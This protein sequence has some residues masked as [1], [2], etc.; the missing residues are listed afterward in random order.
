MGMFYTL[1][2]ERSDDAVLAINAL[3]D[4]PFD[5][6]VIVGFDQSIPMQEQ[7]PIHV[8]EVQMSP[9]SKRTREQSLGHPVCHSFYIGVRNSRNTEAGDFLVDVL[10]KVIA[11]LQGAVSLT[12]Y[13]ESLLFRKTTSEGVEVFNVEYFWAGRRLEPI[14]HSAGA[15]IRMTHERKQL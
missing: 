8:G 1:L 12:A 2:F 7:P 13:G 4:R 11:K 3:L 14:Q 10:C 15:P 9:R 6:P 5:A